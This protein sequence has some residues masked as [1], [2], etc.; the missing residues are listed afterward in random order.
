MIDRGK[1]IK[2]LLLCEWTTAGRYDGYEPD[3]DSCAK[4]PYRQD[5]FEPDRCC[6][7]L[8]GDALALLKSD[9][10][11]CVVI[12]C[13]ECKYWDPDSGLTARKC[14]MNNTITTQREW[15]SRAVR[16]AGNA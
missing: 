12:T 11:E 16:R 9:K 5:D 14:F 13:A 4:C 10:P 6:A 8:M 15:C 2:G 7:E 3:Y 1:V